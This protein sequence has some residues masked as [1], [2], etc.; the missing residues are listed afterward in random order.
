MSD[1]PH[2]A[3]FLVRCQQRGCICSTFLHTESW[4]GV[5]ERVTPNEGSVSL[6]EMETDNRNTSSV[7][8]SNTES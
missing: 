4:E 3:G 6:L 5:V 1:I 8:R 7:G 2:N